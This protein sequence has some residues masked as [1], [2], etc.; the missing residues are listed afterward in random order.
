MDIDYDLLNKAIKVAYNEN[1]YH[2]NN[3][4]LE[5]A[6]EYMDKN[7]L[8][9]NR[10]NIKELDLQTSIDLVYKFL[11]TIDSNLA[12]SYFNVINQVDEENVPCIHFIKIDEKRESRSRLDPDGNVYIYYNNTSDDVFTILHE[13]LH[14]MNTT[15]VRDGNL[16]RLTYPTLVY[17]EV[18]S[19]LGEKLLGRFLLK[20]KYID[21]DDYFAFLNS[22]ISATKDAAYIVIIDNFFFNMAKNNI[23]ITKDNIM[24]LIENYDDSY[25]K[26]AMKEVMKTKSYIIQILNNYE[27]YLNNEALNTDV[28][29]T[30]FASRYMIAYDYFE[31]LK[32][33]KNI[34]DIFLKLHYNI[35]NI[36][37]DITDII[38][39]I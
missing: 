28:L 6:K 27:K 32:E 26:R 39:K 15:Y 16:M 23:T 13:M 36:N 35:G 11:L 4:L 3:G 24:K 8:Y 9:D 12:N 29:G 14:K 7:Y 22:K 21:V 25:I 38:N 2:L 5:K 30:L 17:G 19:Y 10:K 33:N 34:K 1:G 37:E 20:N 31:R 18:V